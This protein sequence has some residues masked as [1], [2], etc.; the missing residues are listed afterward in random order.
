M[1]ALE[2]AFAD[3][4]RDV[5]GVERAFDREQPIAALVLLADAD[6]LVR[7]AVQLLA[8]LH[9]DQRALLLDHDDEIEP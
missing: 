9:F 3:A 6:R 1:A 4:D 8:D 7:G 2:Q 5:V